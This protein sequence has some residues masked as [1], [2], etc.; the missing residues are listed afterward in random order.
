MTLLGIIDICFGTEHSD[1]NRFNAWQILY[2]LVGSLGALGIAYLVFRWN[3]RFTKTKYANDKKEAREEKYTYFVTMVKEIP[4]ITAGQVS[5]Y[6]QHIKII[7]ADPIKYYPADSFIITT[8]KRLSESNDNEQYLH[9]FLSASRIKDKQECINSFKDLYSYIDYKYSTLLRAFEY[10]EHVKNEKE[11]TI[12]KFI[13]A[14]KDLEDYVGNYLRDVKDNTD[15]PQEVVVLNIFKNYCDKKIAGG[16]NN[17]T[18]SYKELAMPL[19]TNLLKLNPEN[20]SNNSLGILDKA[21]AVK[22]AYELFFHKNKFEI[23]NFEN[24]I[25]QMQAYDN[26]LNDILAKL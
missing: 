26:E 25:E 23:A 2:T 4:K 20:Y 21:K 10:H 15:V 13:V 17:F 18:L 9:S 3:Q 8:L 24:L 19:A 1:G 14:V 12:E 6:Q 7:K 22:N 5:L 11:K 16:A